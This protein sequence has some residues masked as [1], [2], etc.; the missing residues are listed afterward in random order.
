M[1]GLEP[2][3]MTGIRNTAESAKSRDERIA[4]LKSIWAELLEISDFGLDDSFMM[5]GGNS[6]KAIALEV[7]VESEFNIELALEDIYKNLT[8]MKL[9]ELIEKSKSRKYLHI[10]PAQKADYYPLT[11]VQK[12]LYAKEYRKEPR[13]IYNIPTVIVIYGRVDKA[14]LEASFN[15]LIRRHESFRTSYHLYDGNIVQKISEDVSFKLEYAR[16]TEEAAEGVIRG[17]IT[18]FNLEKA[19]LIRAMLIDVN[20]DKQMLAID[21]HHI[22]ADGTSIAILLKELAWIYDGKELPELKIQYKDYAVWQNMM[23]ESDYI[24]EKKQYWT[25][26][27]SGELPKLNLPLD[28]VRSQGIKPCEDMIVSEIHEETAK[29]LEKI[30]VQNNITLHAMLF[31][32]YAVLLSRY[33]GQ[34]DL[35]IGLISAGRNNPDIQNIIGVFINILPIRV[36]MEDNTSFSELAQLVHKTCT[37]AFENQDCPFDMILESIPQLPNTANYLDNPLINTVFMLHN[38]LESYRAMKINGFRFENYEIKKNDSEIDLQVDM[39][40]SQEGA[41]SVRFQYSGE[42]FLRSTIEHMLYHYRNI[43][44]EV[45]QNPDILLADIQMLSAEERNQVIAGFNDT[46][47]AFPDKLL[48]QLFEEQ[49]EKTQHN[50]AVIFKDEQLTY[51]EL[52]RKSNQ[53]AALLRTKG[54]KPGDI[55][56]IMVERSIDMII[57]IMAVIKAG[58]AYLPLDPEYPEGRIKYMLT[59]SNVHILLTQKNIAEDFTFEGEMIDLR[60]ETVFRGEGMNLSPVNSSNDLVYV[61]YTSG[62]TGKPKGVMV[63]HKNL[64]NMAFAWRHDYGLEKWEVNLLQIASFSFDVFAGDLCRALLN[65][66]KLVICPS[67]VRMDPISLYRLIQKHSISIFES[68]PSLILPFMEYVYD[69]HLPLDHLRLLILGSDS[70][71]VQDFKKLCKRY[72][73]TMRIINSYGVTEATIDSS[74]Y[75]MPA[76]EIKGTNTVPIGKP[77]QN[78]KFYVLNKDLSPQP[79]RCWGEL[80]IGGIGVARGYLNKPELTREKFIDNPFVPGEKMYKTGDVARWLPDGNMEFLG[81]MDH[82]VKIR[83]YRIE[84]EEIESR[85]TN[86]PAIEEAVVTAWDAGGDNKYLCAYYTSPQELEG[87]ELSEYLAKE[88]TDFMIPSYFVRIEKIPLTP[89][90]K[91][92]R[93]ALPEPDRRN[94]ST[95]YEAPTGETEEKLVAILQQVLGIE[96]IG[97]NNNFFEL[98]G[99]SL[100]AVITIAQIH[101]QLKA[102]LHISELF[103][104]QTIRDIAKIINNSTKN[105]LPEIEAVEEK[106]SYPASSAQRSIYIISRL[107]PESM[108]YNIPLAYVIEGELDIS[109]VENIFGILVKRHESLRTRFIEKDGEVYQVVDKEV[110]T[111]FCYYEAEDDLD[112]II[113]NSLKPF[114][115]AKAPLFRISLINTGRNKNILLFDIHHIITDARSN[116]ILL[117]EFVRLYNGEALPQL[118]IQYRDYSAWQSRLEQTPNMA[119]QEDF[120]LKTLSGYR[121]KPCFP[122]DYERPELQSFDGDSIIMEMDQG[123]AEELERYG[124]IRGVTM[125]ML[126][127]AAY[128]V[129]LAYYSNSEDI[130]VGTPISGRSH[131]DLESVVGIFVNMLAIRSCPKKDALFSSYLSELK[132]ILMN[133][134]ENQYYQF[135][136]LVKKLGINR[137]PNRNPIFDTVFSYLDIS[138]DNYD[139]SMLNIYNYPL[140]SSISKF[141]MTLYVY[142]R[143]SNIQL[144]LEYCT[145][146]YKP[147]TIEQF[148]KRYINILEKLARSFDMK[149][150]DIELDE[151][152]EENNDIGEI[153]FDFD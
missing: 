46:F 106:E 58:G 62:T 75:E 5:L 129:L 31:S 101:R 115:L 95:V 100:K 19:P 51:E 6:L 16:T 28:F 150:K 127:F 79:V 134:F 68:T 81:R 54:I 124:K 80:Y 66:G 4:I 102:E 57:A 151:T 130:V 152:E 30:A 122:T 86:H 137:S 12:E 8:I 65:G 71:S 36:R 108:S 136:N 88:L 45:A 82:Q 18:P 78:T 117:S 96:K 121:Q 56:G 23:L 114:D 116:D 144:K 64:V 125:Y 90:G 63:E 93:K 153:E 141:D 103:K 84:I 55:V 47:R 21:M 149:I 139:M 83:G 11:S 35:I 25:E 119:K 97:I 77:M 99:N 143:H 98:G 131:P 20:D 61:I 26:M 48:H 132:E 133:S 39:Y 138:P 91:I 126:L 140:R 105:E 145:A 38:E 113:E 42:L 70:V 49:V 104:S 59:D 118:K 60:D 76:S 24:K 148:M 41:I 67:D 73:N 110:I 50:T 10:E 27:L 7:R 89:N 123:L 3:G 53:L 72:Q 74:F 111:P 107:E 37:G 112:S 147:D 40:I 17:F 2:Q 87:S 128:N 32:A 94:I 92:D 52:N 14:R 9:A 43:V 33:C 69:S 120:W 22:A 15:I 135:E 34:Q 85:L 146:L 142:R 109:K 29:Q 13:T 1:D 44:E